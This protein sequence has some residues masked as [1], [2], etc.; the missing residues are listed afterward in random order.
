MLI[1]ACKLIIST[2]SLNITNLP[3]RPSQTVQLILSLDAVSV[4]ITHIPAAQTCTISAHKV[5]E[6]TRG[7][8]LGTVLL[9]RS[10]ATIIFAVTQPYCVDAKFVITFKFLVGTCFGAHPL[11]RSVVT[12]TGTV[13]DPGYRQTL[14]SRLTAPLLGVTSSLG[15]QR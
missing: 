1:S 8:G 2:H 4:T 9:I 6:T 10:V 11:I 13:A 3:I 15:A 14:V 5:I 7:A 12:V